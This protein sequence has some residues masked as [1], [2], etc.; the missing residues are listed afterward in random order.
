MRRMNWMRLAFEL[1]HWLSCGEQ[2]KVRLEMLEKIVITQ[3]R[4]TEEAAVEREKGN[5]SRN[6]Y[7]V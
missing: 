3:V 5:N 2:R 6:I 4:N 1:E 7:E